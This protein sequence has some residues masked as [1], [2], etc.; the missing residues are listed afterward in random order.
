MV[1][2]LIRERGEACPLTLGQALA[3]ALQGAGAGAGGAGGAADAPAPS[4]EE[5]DGPVSP[6]LGTEKQGR[7]AMDSRMR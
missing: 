4:T 1:G 6:P 3:G 2:G 5:A 7:F